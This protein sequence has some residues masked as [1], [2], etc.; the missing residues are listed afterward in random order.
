[1][2]WNSG[3]L[4]LRITV[5]GLTAVLALAVLVQSLIF[6]QFDE[7]RVR[8]ALTHALQDTHRQIQIEGRISP[9]LFPSPGID[10]DHIIITEP[11]QTTPFA[12][13]E[14]ANVHLAWWPLFFGRKEVKA[15]GLHGVSAH[16]ERDS[17]GRLS[18]AD[19]F[20]RR[21]QPGIT[22]RLD[23]VAIREG[24]LIVNDQASKTSTRLESI[25]L[26]ADN[27]RDSASLSAGALLADNKR[28][29]R[30]AIN[31]PL[32]IQDDQVDLEQLEAVALS[33]V[34]GLGE[35]KLTLNGQFKLNFATLQTTGQNLAITFHSERPSSEVHL[36]LPTLNASFREITMPSGKLSA[37]L[38]YAHSE[39]QLD[40]TLD[41]LKLD[42][43]GLYADRLKGNF[44]W[45]AGKTR[46]NVKLN[47][48][49]S[50]I[51]L[52]Q[53]HMQPLTLTAAIS[54]PALPRGT[55]Q[56]SMSGSLDGNIDEPRFDLHV[57]GQLDGS[58]LSVN[59]TQFGLMRPR[60][61]ATLS[62]GKLDLNRYLPEAKGNPVAIF[63]D[64]K[65]LALDWL[66]FFDLTGKVSVGELAVG[67]F[68]INNVSSDVRINP[69]ELELDQMSADIYEGRLQ[70]DAL[71][72]RRDTPHLQLKQTLKGMNIRPLLVDLFNFNRLDGKG[73]GQ[74]D[75]NADGKSFAELRNALTGSVQMSLNKGALNGIDLVA[76]LKNLPAELKGW[77]ATAQDGQKTTFSTLSASFHL[78]QGVAR[79]QD[80]KLAS[81]LVNVNGNGKLDLKQNIIDYT[82]DVQANPHEF[83][84]F[85]GIDV[86]LKIT[87]P[88]NAP[89]YALDYNAMVKGKKTE[90]EKQ[91]ALKQEL[92][93]Q[94][95]TILP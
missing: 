86:P 55:L 38:V 49:L 67:R 51:G 83:S 19:L 76:A 70:G 34:Q 9:S 43:S 39:Y 90:G 17:D 21:H 56:S 30:L 42:Q 64:T 62:V 23:T 57:A 77:N 6:W 26:D 20:Q 27:L 36:T 69:H 33:N 80:M 66:D 73:N 4:W 88:I 18:I 41:S 65:P 12:R 63:Q 59:V 91:Q 93:K 40:T 25:N 60:H 11:G 15:I 54:T 35:S 10:I 82:M 28:P 31:T 50:I 47:S 1:M 85:K 2:K 45:L 79:S 74:V 29:V 94:I 75:V 71:L 8:T 13:I 32:T 52:K 3:R 46:V 95:T 72:S 84:R 68:R 81:Q 48:P 53:L 7:T 58:N 89:V 16:V 78:D 24:T 14:Q 87:G 22:I 5:Y 37:K 61:E 44:N 92:K